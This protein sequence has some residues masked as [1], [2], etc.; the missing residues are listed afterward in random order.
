[1]G[2]LGM[3]GTADRVYVDKKSGKV[4]EIS[5]DQL[6]TTT[7]LLSSWLD[8]DL[9]P[10]GVHD[11]L[12]NVSSDR[13]PEYR[14]GTLNE[15]EWE[16]RREYDNTQSVCIKNLYLFDHSGLS[17]STAIQG[18][19]DTSMVGVIGVMADTDE[20]AEEYLNKIVKV[21]DDFLLYGSINAYTYEN[22]FTLYTNNGGYVGAVTVDA[23]LTDEEQCQQAAY[24]FDLSEDAEW[25][26][27]SKAGR[28][29][30]TLIS[31]LIAEN[32][33][34]TLSDEEANSALATIK[35][36]IRDVG[37]SS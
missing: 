16:F 7:E 13:L 9:L 18:A 14:Q 2:S 8:K 12:L 20:L 25:V 27:L 3:F 10:E 6:M 22:L 36:V 5:E 26:P 34:D 15:W 21:W 23:S 35:S 28:K 11:V 37:K 31:D 17:I 30:L 1:M 19:W 32:D 24:F 29:V 4:I 33:L